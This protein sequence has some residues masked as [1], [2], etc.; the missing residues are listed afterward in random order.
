[1]KCS[2][3]LS[4]FDY[5]NLHVFMYLGY[6]FVKKNGSFTSKM[7][8]LNMLTLPQNGGS[9]ISKDLKFQKFPREDA[10]GPPTGGPP[11]VHLISSNASPK[12]LDPP[13]MIHVFVS[14]LQI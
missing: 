12:N 9:R 13:Q 2:I 10:P 1:M 7:R 11:L 4:L 6:I 14:R 8:Y 5:E 3:F